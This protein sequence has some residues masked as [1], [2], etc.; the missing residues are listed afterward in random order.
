M[1]FKLLLPCFLVLFITSCFAQEDNDLK[2][3]AFEGGVILGTSISRVDGSSYSG[4]HKI[5]LHTGAMVTWHIHSQFG[6]SMEL[7][8]TQKGARGG[9]VKES[10]YL[11]TY[12]DKYFLNLHYLELP[13]MLHYGNKFLDYEAGIAYSRLLKADEW[14]EA[15]V[16]VLINPDIN[17]FYHEDIEGVAG[18]NA[19][20]GKHWRGGFRYQAS[21]KPIRNWDRMPA[22]Y[23]QF[24]V[25]EYNNEVIL[26]VIYLL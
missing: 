2:Q 16:P 14:A 10:I 21:L 8:Y 4:Y 18:I 23:M 17:T 20:L 5:G 26:R 22:R 11:G 25:N 19:R 12:I 24:G 6:V 15:D 13:F 1:K 7:L 3:K 9:N